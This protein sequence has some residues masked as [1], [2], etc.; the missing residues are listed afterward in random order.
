MH[1]QEL[2]ALSRM[3]SH[4]ALLKAGLKQVRSVVLQTYITIAKILL[5]NF[6]HASTHPPI[7]AD[8]ISLEACFS[9]KLSYF[10]KLRFCLV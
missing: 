2:N 9:Y 1:C 3:S 7:I 10:S 4:P 8:C 5:Y 6:L